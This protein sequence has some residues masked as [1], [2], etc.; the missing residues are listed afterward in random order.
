MCQYF[1]TDEMKESC[2]GPNFCAVCQCN[3]NDVKVEGH[4]C[5]QCQKR[6]DEI[7]NRLPTVTYKGKQY[8]IDWRLK[9]FRTVLPP[10][11]F[12]P[13]DSEL[14]REIDSVWD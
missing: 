5:E 6:L 1:S 9:E 14:G 12:V 13:F 11:E 10:L 3:R 2:K 8:F 4:I 7:P